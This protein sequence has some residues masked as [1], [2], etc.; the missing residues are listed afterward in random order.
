MTC[1]VQELSGLCREVPNNDSDVAIILPGL[2]SGVNVRQF[3]MQ[4]FIEEFVNLCC[5]HMWMG[6][7]G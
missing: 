5:F 6:L 4:A 7:L 3:A 1:V 2:E